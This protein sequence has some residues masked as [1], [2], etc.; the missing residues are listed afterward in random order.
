MI[1]TPHVILRFLSDVFQEILINRI[2]SIA[3][4]EL[5]PK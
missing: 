3:K 5:T 2:Q 1:H 4:F